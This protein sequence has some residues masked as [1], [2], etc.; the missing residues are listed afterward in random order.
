[1]LRRSEKKV[2]NRKAKEEPKPV[3]KKLRDEKSIKNRLRNNK[4]KI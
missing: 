1:M 4:V 2:S 3:E